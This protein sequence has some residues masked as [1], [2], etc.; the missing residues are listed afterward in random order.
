[1]KQNTDS[2][3]NFL[4]VGADSNTGRVRKANEDSMTVFETSSMKVFAVC[5]GMGGHVGGQVASQTA[6][7]AIRDFLLNNITL[8][9]R[10]AIHNAIIF[11]NTAIL[12][13]TRRQ[14]ELSGMGSTCVMLA[15]TGDGK[16]YY[17][18]VGDSRIYIVASRRITQ[19]TKDHSFVQSLVDAGQITKEQ[20][21]HHPRKNE[22]TN[23]LGLPNMQP[24]TVCTTPIEPESGN[25]FLLCSDGL[26]GM[27]GDEH[28]Q[29]IVS[30]HEIPIQQRTE[31][32]VK[33]ANSNGGID[34]ITVELVEFALGAQQIGGGSGKKPAKRKKMLMYLLPTLAVLGGLA[35]YFL[36]GGKGDPQ[37]QPQQYSKTLKTF[38]SFT[39]KDSAEY[40]SEKWISLEVPVKTAEV[41][42][43]FREYLRVEGVKGFD[44]SSASVSFKWTEKDFFETSFTMTCP[45]DSVDYLITVHVKRPAEKKLEITPNP[46]PTPSGKT[47]SIPIRIVSDTIW[48]E[49]AIP[50]EIT[51][52]NFKEAEKVR[53]KLKDGST[54]T[55]FSDTAVIKVIGTVINDSVN[56][57]WIK[58]ETPPPEVTF[59]GEGVNGK[60]YHITLQLRKLEAKKPDKKDKEGSDTG[61]FKSDS[62]SLDTFS[63]LETAPGGGYLSESR[64][65]GLKDLQDWDNE[66]S[67]LRNPAD[68][69]I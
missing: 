13:K 28:I 64:F 26:T 12:D 40:K 35:W 6:T 21:E 68:Q 27:V 19:L 50:R 42:S 32:L 7:E 58:G 55:S 17:G 23:A 29:R 1:M 54:M 53:L 67:C 8:D 45:S 2:N 34:N 48:M 46:T 22:I 14:P 65:T 49:L 4:L 63:C 5:D 9:P 59:T 41:D 56:I 44:N 43:V 11:A 36:A 37:P 69:I 31:T 25:C 20:A 62:D 51:F 52:T 18:H 38:K 24:P 33:M 47:E 57:M 10:E 39:L 16:A 66:H 3:F 61:I 30:K 15:V 60:I